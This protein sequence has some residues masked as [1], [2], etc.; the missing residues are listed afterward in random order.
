VT[1]SRAPN[2]F[3]AANLAS[4]LGKQDGKT[5]MST[6]Y[7]S[8]LVK[9]VEA[10]ANANSEAF[11]CASSVF[12]ETL[13]YKGL[14]HLYGSGHSVLPVQET[15]PRYGSYVGFNLLTDPREMWHNVLGA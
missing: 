12:A 11:D 3:L 6:L 4:A 1:D 7:I 9:I 10:S 15:F 2:D 8:S 13:L 5:R 14:V